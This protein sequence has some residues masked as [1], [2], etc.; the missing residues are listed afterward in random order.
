MPASA[1]PFV[2]SPP[3]MLAPMAGITDLPFRSLVATFGAGLVVSE[4]VASQDML[5]ARPGSREKAELGLG[6]VGTAV[7]LAGR[8]AAPMAEAARMVEGQGAQ[9]IDINMGCPAKKVTQGFS[10]SALMRTPDHALTLI[11][12]VVNSVQIPVTLKTRL[13]WDDGLLNAPDIARRAEAA[14]IRLITIHGRTR[15]QFYKGRA[16]WAAINAVKRAVSIPVIA[17]GDIIDTASARHALK[18]SGADGI[19]IGRGVRGRPWLLAQIA[20]DLFATP[21]PVVPKAK[22]YA[23][24]VAQ[25]YDAMIAFY[26]PDVGLR[27]ARKHLGWYM[28]SCATPQDLRQAVLRATSIRETQALIL[29]ACAFDQLVAA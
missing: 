11:E 19:M 4:M 25:H 13:G 28:D 24:M 1:F 18:L 12:A 26:G 17:N 22:Q 15:C 14:G 6:Q 23:E 16:D 7:Q 27:V 5:N 10:G 21:A 2:L 29:Q 20:H 9:V 3:V 8:E